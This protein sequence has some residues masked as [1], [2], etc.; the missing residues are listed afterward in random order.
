MRIIFSPTK[1]MR[2]L[3]GGMRGLSLPEMLPKTEC[4]LRRLKEMTGP[5]LKALWGCS[6]RIASQN[7]ERIKNT[8]LRRDLSPA[9]LSFEGISFRYMA[10]ESFR[11]KETEYVQEHLRILSGFYG[12]LRPMDGIRAYRLDAADRLCG[13]SF[14]DLYDFWGGDI[15]ESVR[16]DS[17]VI[18]N[19]ASGEYSVC[20]KK[21]LRPED[22]FINC[23]FAEKTDGKLRQKGTFAKMAR[24]A[25][26][27]FMAEN[28]TDSPEMVKSFR[29]LGFSFSPEDSSENEYVFIRE[30]V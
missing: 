23:S 28:S 2:E 26:L 5:E 25:M 14:G 20:I 27:R 9:L 6:D 24:G 8:D 21:Y 30:P 29:G 15:Y 4:L 19:L 17:G 11:E 13:E 10:P 22:R 16:D 3:P 12:V 1:T 7:L 18:I